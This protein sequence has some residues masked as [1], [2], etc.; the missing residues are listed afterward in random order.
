MSDREDS[1]G[2]ATEVPI[3]GKVLEWALE[4]SGFTHEEVAV[5]LD[6][7]ESVLASWIA[8][9]E[10]PNLTQF[11]K[12]AEK[13]RRPSAFFLLP[14]PPAPDRLEVAFRHPPE[15]ER[16]EKNP[17]ERRAIRA[18]RRMQH[19]VS[20]A[21]AELG[22][23]KSVD[24]PT[25]QISSDA[26]KAAARFR[27]WLAVPTAKQRRGAP[28]KV[29][30]AWRKALE[31]R[32]ILAFQFPIGDDSCWG[33]S[34]TDVLAPVVAVNTA[35]SPE[36]RSF[37]LFHE[38]GHLVTGTSSVCLEGWKRNRQADGDAV[39]RWCE[40]FAAN[41]LAPWEDVARFLAGRYGWGP[42]GKIESLKVASAVAAEFRISLRAAT[43]RLVEEGAATWALYRS[44][45]PWADGKDDQGGGR[46]R[47]R[48]VVRVAE[49]GRRP[50][51]VFVSA[52]E[53]DVLQPSDV[54]DF[55]DVSDTE[56]D[57]MKQLARR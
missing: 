16:D 57:K 56:L 28:A 2:K 52:L 36:A 8:E 41:A 38:C 13:L 27:A 29:Y 1:V 4:D 49:Y 51:R 32:G 11:R 19:A 42:G 26:V 23:A 48:A 53:R 5:A 21:L 33:F 15:A 9:A 43:L 22:G 20:W 31:A 12:L 46:G 3:T 34:L 7:E 18:A 10:R 37:S 6:V 45:P 14:R 54:A 24:L 44:I 40:R 47:T 25:A 39:E 55:F 50:A 30:E 17:K 35:R